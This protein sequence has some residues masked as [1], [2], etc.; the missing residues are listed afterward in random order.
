VCVKKQIMIIFSTVFKVCFFSVF[1]FYFIDRIKM[2]IFNF[3]FFFFFGPVL[4]QNVNIDLRKIRRNT[5]IMNFI[6]ALK[7]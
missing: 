4:N 1:N 5:E 3:I 2:T 7:F 6:V